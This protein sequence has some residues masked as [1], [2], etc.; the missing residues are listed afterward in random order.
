MLSFSLGA[1]VL[2]LAAGGGG[3][4]SIDGLPGGALEGSLPGTLLDPLNGSTATV[5]KP[6]R[7]GE[8]GSTF[9]SAWNGTSGDMWQ[10]GNGCEFGAGGGAGY[11]G[12]GGG[13]TSPGI[14]GSG[15][16]GS[17]YYYSKII[18]DIVIMGGHGIEPGGLQHDPPLACGLGEWDKTG[19]FA[20][21]GGRGDRTMTSPG[22]NGAIR[23]I[24]PGHY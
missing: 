6:G 10:G 15:G 19:G 22:N 8:T 2:L 18:R 21:K 5:D 13:G 9:N 24:K 1:Q 11:Y 7:P 17:S 12:G 4:G 23:I 16:G 3:A 20:G 14:A